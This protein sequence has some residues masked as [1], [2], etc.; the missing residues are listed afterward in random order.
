VKR[1]NRQSTRLPCRLFRS[2][3]VPEP[4]RLASVDGSADGVPKP[5]GLS[6]VDG[7]G[8]GTVREGVSEVGDMVVLDVSGPGGR[9]RGPMEIIAVQRFNDAC[10]RPVTTEI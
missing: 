6:S 3:G 1:A 8:R 5:D 9:S 7:S 4:D 10:T 2:D